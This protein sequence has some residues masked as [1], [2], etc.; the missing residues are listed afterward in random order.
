MASRALTTRF[1]TTCSVC[2]ESA[3]TIS[4]S[5]AQMIS[6]SISGPI[7]RRSIVSMPR[8]MSPSANDA[9]ADRLPPAER[10]QLP[11]QARAAIHR[12]LD[13]GGLVRAPDRR[14]ASCIS[15]RSAAPMMLIRM[16]LKSC[17][18]PPA[19]RPIASSFCDCRSCS[20][21]ARRSVMSRTNPVRTARLSRADAG[22]RQLEREVAAVGAQPGQLDLPSGER[23]AARRH[24]LVQRADLLRRDRPAAAAARR[25]ARGCRAARSRTSARPRG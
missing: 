6:K 9:R 23:P 10:E 15:S 22:D 21:S 14:A 3:T 5:G 12:L 16:L 1:S 13:L 11:R 7:R 2:P 17:A 8:T 25:C 18:T 4:G 19:S 24:V 20:S